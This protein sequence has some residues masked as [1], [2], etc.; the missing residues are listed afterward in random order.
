MKQFSFL[1]ILLIGILF[2]II[3]NVYAQIPDSLGSGFIENQGQLLQTDSASSLS[4]KC[5]GGA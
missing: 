2:S 4:V 5:Y 1:K 3:G